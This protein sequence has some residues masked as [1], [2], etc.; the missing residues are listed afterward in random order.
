[1]MFGC[2]ANGT[3]CRA[4]LAVAAWGI[5]VVA[6]C[7]GSGPKLAQ[8]EGTLTLDGKPLANKSLMFLPIEG[9]AGNGAGGSSDA[10]GRF[11]LNAMI[12]GAT[13]DYPGIGPGRYR[14]TVFEAMI[15]DDA[16][17]EVA[18]NEPAAAIAPA[19]NDRRS[20]IPAVYG[21]GQS[22]LVLDVP[23]SGGQINVE[24]KSNPGT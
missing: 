10:H 15:S 5:V 24:L 23:E 19:T 16:P 13:R 11:T 22:P 18:G 7:G 20:E 6:G 17:G 8:V 21:T 1:M 4:L 2:G 12:P 9:T 3:R 14:V